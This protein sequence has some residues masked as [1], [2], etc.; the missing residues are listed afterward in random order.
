[1]TGA[2]E[3]DWKRPTPPLEPLLDAST[4]KDRIS[5]LTKA[6]ARAA[7]RKRLLIDLDPGSDV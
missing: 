4:G 5:E 2:V 3:N 1:M 6:C 7:G